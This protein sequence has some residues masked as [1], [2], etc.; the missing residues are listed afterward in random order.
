MKAE[1]LCILGMSPGP[2]PIVKSNVTP[3]IL[4]P[5]IYKSGCGSRRRRDL[6]LAI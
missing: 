3:V 1:W 2:L 4:S 6:N 5:N